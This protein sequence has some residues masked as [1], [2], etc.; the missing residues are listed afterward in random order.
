[1]MWKEYI[2]I[3]TDKID[4]KINKCDKSAK[5]KIKY[6]GNVI[7]TE[8]DIQHLIELDVIDFEKSIKLDEKLK[9]KQEALKQD[10]T[11][12]ENIKRFLKYLNDEQTIDELYEWYKNR[13]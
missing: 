7:N 3:E 10:T 4:K 5:A 11:E 8:A 12:L 6:K 2:K 13:G 1:M 9:E